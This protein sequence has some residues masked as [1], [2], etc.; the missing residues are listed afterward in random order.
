MN[1]QTPVELIAH[2]G[3]FATPVSQFS[4]ASIANTVGRQMVRDNIIKS[5]EVKLLNEEK[6][7]QSA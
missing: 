1:D 6:V 5:F 4:N 3:L 7:K 2:N